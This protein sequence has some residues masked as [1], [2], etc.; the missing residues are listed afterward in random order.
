MKAV[1]LVVVRGGVAYAYA[2]LHV[3]LQIIDMDNVEDRGGKPVHLPI[4]I[5]FE[6][7]VL[8]ADVPEKAVVWEDPGAAKRWRRYE[9][10]CKCG[11]QLV[12]MMYRDPQA[13][14]GLSLELEWNLG[15]YT[16][17][18]SLKSFQCPDCKRR[19]QW[20]DSKWRIT[21]TYM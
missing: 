11:K 12:V 8:E 3:D 21:H 20:R 18:E 16:A 9:R 15:A 13:V 6:E 7:L 14:G 2:P 19:I 5:G 17:A 1:A 4:N 10:Y